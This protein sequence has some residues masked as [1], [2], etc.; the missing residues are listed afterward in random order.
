MADQKILDK[1]SKLLALSESDNPNEAAI[2]LERAQKLMKEH[3][4]TMTDVSLSAI[5]EH[6]ESIPTILK[7]GRLYT[8][9]GDIISRS[10]G[11]TFLV[12]SKH[13]N[14]R[15]AISGVCFIGPNDR[16]ETAGYVFTVIARQLAIA[17][18][19]FLASYR[20]K[21]LE[22][23]IEYFTSIG[24]ISDPETFRKTCTSLPKLYKSFFYIKSSCES[25]LRQATKAYLRGWLSSVSQKIDDFVYEEQETLLIEQ[26]IQATYPH[27]R[28]LRQHSVRFNREQMSHYHK[29]IKDADDNV[30]L[31]R[32]VTG[33]MHRRELGFKG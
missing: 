12:I 9:L 28:E 25:R 14:S 15:T 2:A 16:I 13:N 11:V 30:N 19:N 24:Y 6:N 3:S 4:V 32:G 5:S 27:L 17:K 1:I 23:M 18:K 21:L 33:D 29:G 26:Y 7:D 31:F 10:F 22:E 20:S 8:L